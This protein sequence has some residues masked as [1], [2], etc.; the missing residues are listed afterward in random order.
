[1]IIMS[2]TIHFVLEN[3]YMHVC[4]SASVFAHTF[5]TNNIFS[6]FVLIA[7]IHIGHLFI[8]LKYILN[9]L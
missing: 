7:H 3:G 9:V 8:L 1:M 5:A 6:L 2:I 4:M